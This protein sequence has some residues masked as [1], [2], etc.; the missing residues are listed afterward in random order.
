MS[1]NY[2]PMVAGYY[3]ALER[4]LFCESATDAHI[5]LGRFTM[6]VRR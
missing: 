3:V 6:L 5:R 4:T 1:M 2:F